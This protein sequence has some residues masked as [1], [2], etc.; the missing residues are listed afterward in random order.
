MIRVQSQLIIYTRDDLISHYSHSS[1]GCCV[2][3]E[4]TGI[5][6][7]VGVEK[8]GNASKKFDDHGTRLKLYFVTDL[9]FTGL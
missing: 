2:V 4:I 7:G 6:E 3:A 5:V 1:K 9:A 8:S